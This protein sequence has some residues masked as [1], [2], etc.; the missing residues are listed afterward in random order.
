MK[1]VKV[2]KQILKR[3]VQMCCTEFSWL[4]TGHHTNQ[5]LVLL[6]VDDLLTRWA[7]V[8]FSRKDL[9]HGDCCLVIPVN[10][11]FLTVQ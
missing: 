7:T 10:L 4:R 8:K 6:K 3:A 9:H 11:K 2:L 1:V 5:Y